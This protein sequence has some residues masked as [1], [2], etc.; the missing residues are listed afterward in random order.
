MQSRYLLVEGSKSCIT[1]HE[2]MRAKSMAK[3]T[4]DEEYEY[5][6]PLML[7]PSVAEVFKEFLYVD[8]S[9]LE[10]FLDRFK[11]PA[12]QWMPELKLTELPDVR[13]YAEDPKDFQGEHWCWQEDEQGGK[14]APIA[15]KFTPFLP[16]Y[17]FPSAPD[18]KIIFGQH[19]YELTDFVMERPNL[20]ATMMQF[21]GQNP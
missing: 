19:W 2:L 1:S 12:V 11:T 21:G 3:L 18:R 10:D 14:W 7:V 9:A 17:R 16:T 4:G 6:K 5:Y 8:L 13:D 20:R 15:E